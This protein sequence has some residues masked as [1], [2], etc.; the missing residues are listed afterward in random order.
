M[1][2]QSEHR[3]CIYDSCGVA[4]CAVTN[5]IVSFHYYFVLLTVVGFGS[6]SF[7]TAIQF[8]R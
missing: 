6:H 4:R 7:Y 5:L 2:I 3:K 1:C 8:C